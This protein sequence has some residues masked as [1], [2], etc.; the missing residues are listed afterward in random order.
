MPELKEFHHNDY[1]SHSW[2]WGIALHHSSEAGAQV[3]A[4]INLMRNA[5]A[6]NHTHTNFYNNGLPLKVQKEIGAEL[7]GTPDAIDKNNAISPMN[8]GKAKFAALSMI[9]QDLHDS[10]TLCN[11]T[12]PMWASPR[13]DKNYRGDPDAEA[14]FYSAV[15]GIS[16][17]RAELEQDGLRILTLFRALTVRNMNQVDMRTQHDIIPEWAFTHPDGAVPF[18]PGS[19]I[20][21][22]A[23]MELAKDLFYDQLGYDRKTGTPTRAT[24][25]KLNLKD[26]ADTLA[27]KGL[28]PA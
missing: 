16:K 5:H 19:N 9:V 1:D 8:E 22:H 24:L 2:K 3:G 6:Q 7:F 4:L 14:K 21:D 27:S 23:D 26:V 13:K 11:W 15:T 18:E 10:L 25:E 28:L 12:Q 17:T 20:L